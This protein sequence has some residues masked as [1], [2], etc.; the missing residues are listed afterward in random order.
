[1]LGLRT[2]G[3][4]VAGEFANWAGNHRC[5]PAQRVEPRS[6]DEVVA[7]VERAAREGARVKAVGAG[8]SWSDIACTDAIHVS[9]DRMRRVLEVDFAAKRVRVQAG[10]RLVELNRELA[11]R[12]LGLAMLGSIA[13]QSV[14]G[15]IST[16]THGSGARFGILATQVVALRLV[17][18]RGDVLSLSQRESP[19]L[20]RAAVVGLG[21]L[22]IV[23]EVTLQCVDRFRLLERARPEPLDAVLEQLPE[24]VDEAPYFKIWWLPHTG[25]TRVWTAEPTDRPVRTDRR[26]ER[27]DELANAH[28]FGPLLDLGARLP[29]AVPAINRAVGRAYFRPLARVERSDR[30]LNLPMPPVH[31]ETEHAIAVERTPA[32]LRAVRAMIERFNIKVNFPVEVRFGRGDDLTMSPAFGR[33]TCFLG[34]YIGEGGRS[35]ERYFR[36]FEDR[37]LEMGGRPHWGKESSLTAEQLRAVHPNYDAFVEIRDRLDPG[38]TFDNDFLRRAFP[39]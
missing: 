7:L 9:L 33:D 4:A 18:G 21:A 31:R 1:M 36:R 30:V 29:P 39:R 24:M 37:M 16:G 38:G 10:I 34:A 3:V 6:E 26:L 22:G 25:M 13:E 17:T 5:H 27:V 32:A 14:A 35:H 15:A 2:L 8:H 23:T 19:D 28:L 12:R 11:L 20:F